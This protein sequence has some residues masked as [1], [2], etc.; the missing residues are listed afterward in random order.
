MLKPASPTA[1]PLR[2][3]L[4]VIGFTAAYLLAASAW[5]VMI[6]NYEFLA[7]IAIMLVLAGVVWGIHQRIG[8]PR[9]LIWCLSLWGAL[10]MAGGL[11]VLPDA[12]DVGGKSAVLY[13]WHIAGPYFKY[14]QVV[15]AFGFGTTTWLCWRGLKAL[16]PDL[17]TP[18]GTGALTLCAAAGV[19]FGA[20]NEVIE[21]VITV[22]VPENNVGGYVN[23]ALDLVYNLVGAVLAAFLIRWRG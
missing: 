8:L 17:A 3:L 10:H 6:G 16:A 15:H 22:L 1:I 5:V 23:T 7:Y 13:N 11:M 21:F 4:G 9:G 2:E 14:D 19:G 12:F 18:P 20:L